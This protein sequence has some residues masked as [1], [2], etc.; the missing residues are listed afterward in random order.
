MSKN[1]IIY[2]LKIY[3]TIFYIYIYKY[4]AS[5]YNN[6]LDKSLLHFTI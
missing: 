3:Y 1:T 5:I 4:I 6:S 2:T